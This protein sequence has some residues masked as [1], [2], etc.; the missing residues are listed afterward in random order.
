MGRSCSRNTQLLPFS[1]VCFENPQHD[2]R[3]PHRR[4]TLF[5]RP[6]RLRPK[7]IGLILGSH[8]FVIA[9]LSLVERIRIEPMTAPWNGTSPIHT[10]VEYCVHISPWDHRG[11]PNGDGLVNVGDVVYLVSFLYRNGPAPVPMSEGDVNC[12]GIVDIGDVV[13]LVNYL[14]RKGPVPRCCDP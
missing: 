8:E 6:G 5:P 13:F 2:R 3:R 4:R 10:E 9:R 7:R 1:F 12:D 14:Y 11:D